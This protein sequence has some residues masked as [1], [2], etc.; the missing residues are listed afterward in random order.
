M[1]SRQNKQRRGA[2]SS[3]RGSRTKRTWIVATSIVTVPALFIIFG[4]IWLKWSGFQYEYDVELCLKN[5][6]LT[7]HTVLLIDSTDT[8][9]P[10]KLDYVTML[11][12][13]TKTELK[14]FAKFSILTIDYRHGGFPRKVFS[15]CNPGTAATTNILTQAPSHVQAKFEEE[16][17]R[18][19]EEIKRS[20]TSDKASSQSPILETLLAISQMNEFGK[21]LPERKLIIYSDMMQNMPTFSHYR[22]DWQSLAVEV[23]ARYPANFQ[24]VEISV[25]YKINDAGIQ[26]TAHREFWRN[27]FSSREADYKFFLTR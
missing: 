16:F 19:L 17:L 10:E 20:F 5:Q 23:M 11:I 15:L 13:K 1:N 8:F 7:D 24:N 14:P 2:K 4:A 6:P 12:D 18:P 22:N 3:R 27:Y 9:A 26:N 21:D 25:H